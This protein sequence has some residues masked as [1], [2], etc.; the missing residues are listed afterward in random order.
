MLIRWYVYLVGFDHVPRRNSDSIDQSVVQKL[1]GRTRFCS[2]VS[3]NQE[4]LCVANK[5]DEDGG[6]PLK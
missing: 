6:L 5:Y 4:M 2:R 3:L 1:V